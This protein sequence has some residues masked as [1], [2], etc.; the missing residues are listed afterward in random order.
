MAVSH[1]ISI[2]RKKLVTGEQLVGDK[3][4]I[5]TIFNTPDKFVWDLGGDNQYFEL[6]R[7]GQLQIL[8]EQYIVLLSSS[9]GIGVR[10]FRPLRPQEILTSNYIRI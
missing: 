6:Y 5:N 7:N 1:S 9:K 3:N 4:N 2:P 10:M 8:G